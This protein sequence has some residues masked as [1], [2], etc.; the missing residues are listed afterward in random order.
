[1]SADDREA[2]RLLERQRGVL[3]RKQAL[4]LVSAEALRH[5]LRPGG[6][7]QKLLPGVYLTATGLATIGQRE[8]AALLYAGPRSVITGVGAL[9]HREPP[10]STLPYSVQLLLASQQVD[11][12]VPGERRRS[13]RDFAVLHRTKV[14]PRWVTE[15]G[16]ARY[17][18]P[19]RAVADTVRELTGYSDVRAVVADTVQR[20]LCRIEDLAEELA[21]GPHRGSGLLRRALAEVTEGVR[22]NPEGDLRRLIIVAKLPMPLFNH[23]MYLNG[24]FLARPDAYWPDYGVIAEID[25]WR[26]HSGPDDFEYT[27]GRHDLI[28]ATGLQALHCTP[29]QLHTKPRHVTGR[30]AVTLRNGRPV[31]GIIAK[32]PAT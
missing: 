24:K 11:V 6:P 3:S 20:Q 16:A 12:L 25:S 30:I 4:T 19:A 21:A 22:S 2:R 26:H 9:R 32:P 29:H 1:V 23:A 18:L 5:R 28:I 31:P 8:M 27:W 14:W 10:G 7:W 17:V 13:S 15:D